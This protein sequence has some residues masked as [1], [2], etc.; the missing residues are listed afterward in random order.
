MV[1]AVVEPALDAEPRAPRRA[2]SQTPERLFEPGGAT[3]EDSVLRT[4]SELAEGGRAECPVCGGHLRA[5]E[6]C[7]GCGAEL[8]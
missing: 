1:G 4:W 5:H 6:G 2:G 7:D 3:L 8:A